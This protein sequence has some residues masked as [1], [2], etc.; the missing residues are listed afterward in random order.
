MIKPFFSF[1]K[2]SS[3]FWKGSSSFSYVS[4]DLFSEV[5]F[6]PPTWGSPFYV[7]DFKGWSVSRL[8]H[9]P[10]R[11]SP[12]EDRE[13]SGR[14]PRRNRT[15]IS[16]KGVFSYGFSLPGPHGQFTVSPTPY[17][18]SDLYSVLPYPL[19]QTPYLVTKSTLSSSGVDPTC[20]PVSGLESHRRSYSVTREVHPVYSLTIFI[21]SVYESRNETPTTK[22][23]IVPRE[24][25][26]GLR[27][28][29]GG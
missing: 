10:L 19:R 3:S 24:G 1:S 29:K 7:L 18:C 15:L 4:V 26:I 25:C 8:T 9:R 11:W 17:P 20:S 14:V 13:S 12:P 6:D 2:G 5:R 21:L 28:V 16:P 22:L 23:C 27:S